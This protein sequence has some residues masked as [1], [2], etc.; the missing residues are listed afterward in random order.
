MKKIIDQGF[1][2]VHRKILD[3]EWYDDDNVF[4]VFMHLLLKANYEDGK[5]QGQT[6][7][8]GQLITSRLHLSQQL[9]NKYHKISIQE[10]RTVLSKLKLTGEITVKTTN[11][12][13]VITIIKYNDYQTYNQQD[14]SQTTSNQP[15]INQQSTTNNK[16]NKKN[17]K[18]K[19]KDIYT[20]PKPSLKDVFDEATGFTQDV[21]KRVGDELCV[22]MPDM[23]FENKWFVDY[24]RNRKVPYR[25]KLAGFRNI[26]RSKIKECKV[27]TYK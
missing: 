11:R 18:N 5:W 1:I 6:V 21:L 17:K 8:R 2:Y 23:E 3:W 26:L 27:K 12:Y 4:R 19:K 7:K 15:A 13:S 14:N 16:N 22:K 10:V 9:S 25:D 24:H 20:S